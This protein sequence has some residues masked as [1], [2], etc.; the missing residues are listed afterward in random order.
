MNQGCSESAHELRSIHR[1]IGIDIELTQGYSE[2]A[3]ELR[4]IQ[5]KIGSDIVKNQGSTRSAI[6]SSQESLKL[7]SLQS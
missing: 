5:R 1:K 6:T 2:F 4:S 7:S 3:H